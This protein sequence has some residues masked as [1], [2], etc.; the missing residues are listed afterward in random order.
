LLPKGTA[1]GFAARPN[2]SIPEVKEGYEGA[3]EQTV[4]W[5]DKK[6]TF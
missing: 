5:L 1:H 3:F 2:L 6:L 4:E